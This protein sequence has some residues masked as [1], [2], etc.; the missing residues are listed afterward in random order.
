MFIFAV[1]ATG[2]AGLV[3]YRVIASMLALDNPFPNLRIRPA[4][5]RLGE[6]LEISWSFE[7]FSQ[8]LQGMTIT[9]E[10]REEAEVYE[11][12]VSRKRDSER[13]IHHVFAT[14][15]VPS[16]VPLKRSKGRAEIEIPRDSMHS[17]EGDSSRIIWTLR[18]KTN[19]ANKPDSDDEL[20]ITIGPRRR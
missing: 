11:R 12:S 17:F 5:P 16:E 15:P 10:G 19:V 18:V 20:P 13:T 9:L 7:R 8:A 4:T 2:F 3:G 14:W 1:I 6:K